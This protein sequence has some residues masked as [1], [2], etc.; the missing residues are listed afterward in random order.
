MEN[1]MQPYEIRQM[2]DGRI[3]YNGY[4]ARPILLL[5][6]EMRRFCR[7]AAS[8]KTILIVTATVA[9]LVFTASISTHRTACA[10]C[11]PVSTHAPVG[12]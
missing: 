2:S 10:I 8:L 3:D 11:A 7:Q 12:S 5:T 6:P 1:V 9:A 4:F